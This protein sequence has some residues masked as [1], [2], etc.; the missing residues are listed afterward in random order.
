MNASNLK[1]LLQYCYISN[2]AVLINGK[3]GIGKS[4]IVKQFGN[5]NNLNV[6][7]LNLSLMEPSDLLGMPDVDKSQE[8]PRTIWLEPEWFQRIVDKAWPINFT[9]EDLEFN[10]LEFKE[11]VLNEFK[12]NIENIENI[13]RKDLNLV[14]NSH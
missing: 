13:K 6:E 12:N 11:V 1:E 8:H 5:E 14:E 2:K 9:F 3:H 7:I 4:S 10:D